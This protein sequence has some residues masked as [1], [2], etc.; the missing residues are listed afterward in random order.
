[1]REM[2]ADVQREVAALW[3]R[4]TTENLRDLTD[5]AVFQH[6]FRALFGFEV[7]GVDYS[8]AVETQLSW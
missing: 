4:V 7:D 2:R 1:N 3:P 5:F 6:E 8:A